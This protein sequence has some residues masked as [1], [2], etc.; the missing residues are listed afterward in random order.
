MSDTAILADCEER[1]RRTAM[2]R[3]TRSALRRGKDDPSGK[4]RQRAAWWWRWFGQRWEANPA[5]EPAEVLPEAFALLREDIDR[6]IIEAFDT[7]RQQTHMLVATVRGRSKDEATELAA[8][9]ERLSIAVE[10][11]RADLHAKTKA[12]AVLAGVIGNSDD[13]AAAVKKLQRELR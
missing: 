4:T 9:I 1:E 13:I 6:D 2:V 8:K 7:A 10:A 5:I 11:L 3:T 12:F